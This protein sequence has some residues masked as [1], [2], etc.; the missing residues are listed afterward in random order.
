M[1]Q[2]IY[3]FEIDLNWKLI[4][5]LSKIDRFNASWTALEKREKQNLSQLKAFAT[6]HS[7]GSST[8]IEGSHMKNDEVK[9]LTQ[10][11][12]LSQIEDRD[13]QEV[14]GYYNVLSIITDS[15]IEITVSKSAINNLHN[16]L[17]KISEKYKQHR[18]IRSIYWTVNGH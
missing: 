4:S 6:I 15:P 10:N 3:N 12:K 8:R 11:I 5:Q 17:L 16:Q 2:K 1:T 7:V 14:V 9:A 13:S 18:K